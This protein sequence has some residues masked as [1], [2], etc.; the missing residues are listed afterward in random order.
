[1][2]SND[3]HQFSYCTDSF[4]KATRFYQVEDH[5]ICIR[6]VII[7]VT[8]R[9]QMVIKSRRR[10]LEFLRF[11]AWFWTQDR[12]KGNPTLSVF[13]IF[14]THRKRNQWADF[15][16]WTKERQESISCHSTSY[17]LISFGSLTLA[18]SIQKW[19][20]NLNHLFS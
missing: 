20:W 4:L 18:T 5:L 16:S 3:L 12:L 8:L 14:A 9:D 15:K 13:T 17:G 10:H 1:M 6:A 11:P 7:C 19:K 2:S